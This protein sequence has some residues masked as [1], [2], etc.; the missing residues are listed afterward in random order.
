VIVL[1]TDVLSEPGR[2]VPSPEVAAWLRRQ[3]RRDLY[4][5]TISVAELLTGVALLPAG[6]RRD[7]IRIAVEKTIAEMEGRILPFDE[8]AARAFPE[9]AA[10]R[11]RSGRPIP[12][13][14][15][16]IAAISRSH[17]AAVATRDVRGFAD[18]GVAVVNP[19]EHPA[20]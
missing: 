5:T 11:R 8:A 14:D 15:A 20:G 2:P 10:R 9:I 17:S 7:A 12:L 1:D 19:W 13:F 6:R 3:P 16:L 18:C 4:I